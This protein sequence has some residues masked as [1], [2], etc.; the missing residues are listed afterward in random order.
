MTSFFTPCDG[1]KISVYWGHKL[2]PTQIHMSLSKEEQAL[3]AFPWL[4]LW[5]LEDVILDSNDNIL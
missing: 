2:R 3:S 5:P 1:K 4:M